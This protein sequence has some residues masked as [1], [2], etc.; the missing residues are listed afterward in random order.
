MHRRRRA[1]VVLAGVAVVAGCSL[2][3]SSRLVPFEKPP[4]VDGARIVLEVTGS[5]CEAIGDV[6]VRESSTSV[7]IG[8]E[9]EGDT[10]DCDDLGVPYTTEV[11]LD[12]PL[13]DRTLVDLACES[14]ATA[15]GSCE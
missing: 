13:D 1:P 9:L 12:V 15:T 7:S 14:E 5:P 4:E 6:D 3:A 11:V 2:G 8:V 10:S